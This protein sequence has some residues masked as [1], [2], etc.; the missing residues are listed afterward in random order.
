[1]G[2]SGFGVYFKDA[3]ICGGMYVRKGRNKDKKGVR[4]EQKV[5][6][7]EL[8]VTEGRMKMPWGG[9]S[10]MLKVFTL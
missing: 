3:G 8:K 10:D 5:L 2:N 1:M 9:T 4:I 6:F 7:T